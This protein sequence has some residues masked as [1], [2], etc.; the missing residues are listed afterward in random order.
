MAGRLGAQ[1]F[2]TVILRKLDQLT[3]LTVGYQPLDVLLP[4]TERFFS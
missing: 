1:G 3:L 4:A 2:P